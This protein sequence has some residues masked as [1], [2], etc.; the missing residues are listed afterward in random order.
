MIYTFI[1]IDITFNSKLQMFAKNLLNV[2]ILP[3]PFES[4]IILAV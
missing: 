3:M 4:N 1:K 2:I